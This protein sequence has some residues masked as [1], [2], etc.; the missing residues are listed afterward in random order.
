VR[1]HPLIR[2]PVGKM[3]A[4]ARW[5]L[6]AVAV[7]TLL[8]VAV[9]FAIQVYAQQEARRIVNAWSETAGLSVEDVRYRMLR[10]ALTLVD[11]RLNRGAFQFYAPNMFLHGNLSSLAGDEPAVTRIEMRGLHVSLKAGSLAAF[12]EGR[13]LPMLFRQLWVSAQQVEIHD[14]KLDLLPDIDATIPSQPVSLKVIRLQSKR[15]SGQRAV[16]ALIYGLD[17]EIRLTANSSLKNSTNRLAGKVSW[18]GMNAEPFLE[19]LLGLVPIQGQ[20]S[21]N[22]AWASKPEGMG[23]YSLSGEA[24]FE[25]LE[26]SSLSSS[27][28]SWNGVLEEGRWHGK[29]NGLDWP[30]AMFADYAPQFQGRKLISGNFS[31]AINFS[32]SLKQWQMGVVETYLNNI[33]YGQA[34][35]ENGTVPEW[36]VEKV[37][38]TKAA[39][40]WPERRIDINNAE[41]MNADL[42]FDA[43]EREPS[44]LLWSIKTGEIGLNQVRPALHLPQGVLHLPLMK[45]SFN[46]KENHWAQLSLKSIDMDE[47]SDAE[48]WRISG[49]GDWTAETHSRMAM[50]VA[51]ENAALVRFRALMP[52]KIRKAA[53]DL[54]GS[55]NMKLKLL[56]GTAPWEGSGEASISAARLIYQ[57]EQWQAEKVLVDIEKMGAGIPEQLIRHLDVQG[58]R[59]Q[60]ALQP[61]AHMGVSPEEVKVEGN[62]AERWHLK[63]LTL[64][65]GEIAVGHKEAIW[66]DQATVDIKNLKPG[67][68]API[69]IKGRLGEGDLSLRGDLSWSSASPEISSAKISIRDVLPFFI[70]EW[71]GM[72]GAPELVRGRIYTD[73]SMQ[74][75]PD[76]HYRGMWYLRIQH[77]ALGP[78][79][80]QGDPLLERTGFNSFDILSALH[81][82][83]RVRLRIPVEEEGS[84]G[85]ALGN[86]LVKKLNSEMIKK[87]RTIHE[88]NEG[89]GNLLSSVR[90][91][92]KGVLSQNERVRLR[93]VV[94]YLR[95]NPK[96][97][98]E[99]IPRFGRSSSDERQVERSRYTQRLIEQFMNRRGVSLS[100]IFPVWPGEEHRSSGGVGGISIHTLP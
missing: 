81:R 2:H 56:A 41:L 84:F 30:L 71:L 86:A 27:K 40:Q 47:K 73:I 78:V 25:D 68:S 57:G 60:A 38:I 96:Q 8:L 36:L 83:G 89:S 24:G 10:G 49:E 3:P 12:S 63:S 90:L 79:T 28:I 82:G 21:G 20:L 37:H 54:T 59:Y 22:I 76:G 13:E 45:G 29:V 50:E 18:S 70:N 72:S 46:V 15:T 88:A 17:G 48:R 52:E 66:M 23:H 5:Y 9:H 74:R 16:E 32:G 43:R 31:G 77:G 19:R 94:L 85:E 4:A 91:H 14:T 7:L 26:N 64:Q 99:L 55:V 33:R 87:E 39:L 62:E 65:N 6:A 98:V 95:K 11:L 93:K 58:W 97:S 35:I 92:E 42:G 44:G 61:L 69:R 75:Q 53:S 80:A 34:F 100:R 67:N 1:S 51:A